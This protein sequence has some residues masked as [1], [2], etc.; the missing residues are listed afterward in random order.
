MPDLTCRMYAI[1]ADDIHPNKIAIHVALA[2]QSYNNKMFDTEEE[3]ARGLKLSHQEYY[4]HGAF[5][6]WTK[7]KDLVLLKES[8]TTRIISESKTNNKSTLKNSLSILNKKQIE[9]GTYYAPEFGNELTCV[10][11]VAD[12]RAYNEKDYP[13]FGTFLSKHKDIIDTFEKNRTYESI[14][15]EIKTNRSTVYLDWVRSIGGERNEFLREFIK[16]LSEI[17]N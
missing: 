5:K 12:E 8:K 10:V 3:I 4:T 14:V 11:F 13:D 9:T 6:Q 2:L 17:T 7:D 15:Q 16:E 1:V